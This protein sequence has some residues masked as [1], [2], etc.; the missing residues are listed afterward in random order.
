MFSERFPDVSLADIKT[1]HSVASTSDPESKPKV[2]ELTYAT[3][4]WNQLLA[5]E[6]V[7]DQ[8]LTDLANARAETIRNAFLADGQFAEH[9][10]V[11]GAPKEVEEA[12][13]EGVEAENREWVKLELGIAT[14]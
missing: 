13:V 9:R 6:V 11:I 14:D 8:D 4:L 3:A 1:E 2:D 7:S 12:A 5:V 10:I